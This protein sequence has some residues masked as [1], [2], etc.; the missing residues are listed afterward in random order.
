MDAWTI[1]RLP[2]EADEADVEAAQRALGD[3]EP[4]PT[5][6]LAKVLDRTDRTIRRWKAEG[7][8]GAP[9]KLIHLMR[10][11]DEEGVEEETEIGC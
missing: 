2:S 10:R 5:L 3:D 6:V 1:D 11:L 8:R 7:C 4:V 9:A